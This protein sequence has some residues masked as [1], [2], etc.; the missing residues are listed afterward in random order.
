MRIPI[1]VA[2][3]AA[4]LAACGGSS[5]PTQAQQADAYVSAFK[6]QF[7][8]VSKPYDKSSPDCAAT[9][10]DACLQDILTINK[11]AT[12]APKSLP[13]VPDCM[14]SADKKARTGF[15]FIET[16]SSGV[17]AA[18]PN[19]DATAAI[20]NMKTGMN[21]LLAAATDIGNAKC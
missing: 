13:A 3:F 10:Q 21:E 1:L 11:A 16:G 18:L 9:A 4:S 12:A 7:D 19:G 6:A 5:G 17:I 15:T 2:I 8:K 14:S 20:A